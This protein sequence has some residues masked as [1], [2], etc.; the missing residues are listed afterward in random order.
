MV[1]AM[2]GGSGPEWRKGWIEEHEDGYIIN[3]HDCGYT[4][5]ALRRNLVDGSL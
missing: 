4:V 3:Y 1:L 2:V 5:L